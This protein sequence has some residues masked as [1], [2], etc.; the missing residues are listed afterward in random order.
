[1]FFMIHLQEVIKLINR[2]GNYMK[3]QLLVEILFEKK[4][5]VSEIN[6]LF[7]YYF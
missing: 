3:S 2:I 7:S 4:N 1:M 6:V 5:L